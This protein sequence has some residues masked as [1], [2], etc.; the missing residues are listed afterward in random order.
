MFVCY[1]LSAGWS[2]VGAAAGKLHFH[3]PVGSP[4]FDTDEQI[5]NYLFKDKNSTSIFEGRIHHSTDRNHSQAHH[6]SFLA[7]YLI[8]I[9]KIGPKVLENGQRWRIFGARAAH[10]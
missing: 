1:G 6:A 4:C 5:H 9:H 10:I 2:V 7:H 3:A 8:S